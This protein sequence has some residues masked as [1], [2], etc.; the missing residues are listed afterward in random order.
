MTV[1]HSRNA[2]A[3]DAADA[4]DATDAK[5]LEQTRGQAVTADTDLREE[6][7]RYAD[8]GAFTLTADTH[9]WYAAV[10]TVASPEDARAAS[11]V[12]AELRGHDLQQTWEDITAL[13]AEVKIDAPD[14]V[15]KTA[16]L[17]EMLQLVHR[18]STILTGAAYDADLGTLVA[19]TADRAWR[20]ERGVKLSWLRARSLRKQAAALAATSGRPRPQ[21]LHEALASAEVERR[22]WTALAP[23][24]TL[25]VPPADGA[26]VHR[27]ALAFEAINTGLRDLARLLPGQDLDALSFPDLVDL[28]DR[29]A[30]DEGTLYRL[31][32]IRTLRATLEDAGLADLLSELT[33]S[34]A[35]RRAAEAAYT[36]RQALAG[37]QRDGLAGSG[38]PAPTAEA[39]AADVETAGEADVVETE[40]P[41]AAG[42]D[43]ADTETDGVAD[44]AADIAAEAG[45]DESPV[46]VEAPVSEAPGTDEAEAE[47]AV[48]TVVASTVE[49]KPLVVTLPAPSPAA[50]D[51]VGAAP[52]EP[53]AAEVETVTEE[54]PVVEAEAEAADAD[55]THTED[56]TAEDET[57]A[58][59]VAEPVEEVVTEVEAPADAVVE[60]T[61]PA[62]V[63][64]EVVAEETPVVEAPVE[65]VA[66]ETP[67]VEVVAELVA[68]L[69]VEAP[70][71]AEKVEAEMAEAVVVET[72][73]VEVVDEASAEPVVEETAPAVGEAEVVAEEVPVV[74]VVAEPVV[75]TPVVAEKAAAV[76][77]AVVE[78]T[79]AVEAPV[80]EAPVEAEMAEAVVVETASVEVVDEAPAEPVADEAAPAVAEEVPVVEAPVEDV[81]PEPV[82]EPVVVADVVVD[83]EPETPVVVEPAAVPAARAA[84]PAFTPG[85]PVTAYSA[86]ELLAIVR[87]I[88]GDGVGRSDEE[89]LRAAMKE[90]GF[91]R[92]GPRI[93]DALGTAVTAA[94]A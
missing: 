73:S 4:K 84:K 49:E 21:D 61:A 7:G 15:G 80:V 5:D 58:E 23:A 53:S 10:D 43:L 60:E 64:A 19:A 31:P 6:L 2:D 32:T 45:V 87:W 88:D 51:L 12:L 37:G 89:L 36:A 30:A 78:E 59:P 14:T 35:D 56:R 52:V 24:G 17:V 70:V 18:T 46:E 63:E 82:V 66:E 93:K 57:E 13:A 79:A 48:E 55:E 27:T 94:R 28:V 20:R 39:E 11:T 42:T 29:L 22:A 41:T 16:V 83:A 8:L 74:E 38:E 62:V 50:D 86:E 75:E 71:E 34:R 1:L 68:E 76:E 40:A 90:L 26:L 3:A 92:L 91:A 69:V 47:A 9:A 65:V 44:T 72:T 54:T 81:A 25:P 77:V 33:A 67:A 85:R